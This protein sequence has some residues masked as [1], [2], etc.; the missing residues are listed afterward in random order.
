M[1]AQYGITADFN[2]KKR[3]ELLKP[4]ANPLFAVVVVLA[5]D[6]IDAAEKSS[7]DASRNAVINAHFVT[8]DDCMAGVGRHDG[9]LGAPDL[10]VHVLTVVDK[11]TKKPPPG[12]SP[13]TEF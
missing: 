1:I 5:R 10:D 3:S 4:G 7:S 9:G 13:V 11:G 12:K 6:R 2:S 8:V